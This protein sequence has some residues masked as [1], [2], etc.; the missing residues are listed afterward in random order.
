MD[1]TWS[2]SLAAIAGL[3]GD[4]AVGVGDI[5]PFISLLTK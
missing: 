2:E 3:S 5:N 1:Q 4:H